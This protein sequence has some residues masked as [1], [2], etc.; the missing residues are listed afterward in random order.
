[1]TRFDLCDW[2]SCN[3]IRCQLKYVTYLAIILICSSAFSAPLSLQSRIGSMIWRTMS[4][5]SQYR[6]AMPGCLPAAAAAR[7]TNL[8]GSGEPN[9]WCCNCMPNGYPP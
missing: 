9:S 4:F 6:N 5:L 8:H 1:Y 2:E 3:V 7:T